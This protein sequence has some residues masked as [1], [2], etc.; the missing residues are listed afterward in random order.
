M[1][2]YTYCPVGVCCRIELKTKEE[3]EA[4]HCSGTKINFYSCPEAGGEDMRPRGATP[5]AG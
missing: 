4:E 1:A 5:Y 3:M 2:N